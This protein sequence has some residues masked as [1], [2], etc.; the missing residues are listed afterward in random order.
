MVLNKYR[1]LKQAARQAG[2]E[3]KRD[4]LKPGSYRR[5]N[6]F[7]ALWLV[8]NHSSLPREVRPVRLSGRRVCQGNTRGLEPS[9][10]RCRGTNT[11]ASAA[12]QGTLQHPARG[13]GGPLPPTSVTFS[14]AAN[15][16]CSQRSDGGSKKTR[17]RCSTVFF[18]VHFNARQTPHG[19]V[20]DPTLCTSTQSPHS[21]HHFSSLAQVYRSFALTS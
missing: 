21:P 8:P 13:A 19:A 1:R 18:Q 6:N 10:Q 17:N 9:T 20:S 15:H 5:V 14:S 4:V 16:I 7:P 2:R 12:A 11:F 3:I